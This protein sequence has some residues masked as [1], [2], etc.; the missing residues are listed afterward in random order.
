M[1]VVKMGDEQVVD[2]R[3]TS[4]GCRCEDSRGIPAL[5]S[6][7]PGVDQQRLAGRCDDERGCT[8]LDVNEEDLERPR[9]GRRARQQ[10]NQ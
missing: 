9:A 2:A 8:A 6:V 1:I 3:D 5:A 4:V 7:V 10:D